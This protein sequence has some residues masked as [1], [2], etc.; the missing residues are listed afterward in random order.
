MKN[1]RN[2]RPAR[3]TFAQMQARRARA[4]TLKLIP[5]YAGVAAMVA[6]IGYAI[7]MGATL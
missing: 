2:N 6:V 7:G 4:E 1:A 5:I 3:V